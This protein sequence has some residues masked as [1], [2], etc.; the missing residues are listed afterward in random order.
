MIK[1]LQKELKRVRTR[2]FLI[3]LSAFRNKDGKFIFRIILS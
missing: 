2:F 1:K 3:Y